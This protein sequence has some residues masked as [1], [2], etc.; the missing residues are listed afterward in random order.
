M[1]EKWYE[2]ESYRKFL[3]SQERDTYLPSSVYGKLIKLIPTDEN[4]YI[5]D[6]RT[7]LGHAALSLADAY[8]KNPRLH[9]FACDF[10]EE[11][12]DHFWYTLAKK[13][14]T[15]VTPFFVPR[16]SAIYFPPWL[17]KMKQI[18]C[19]LTLSSS[20]EPE[21]IIQTIHKIAEANA[22]LHIIEWNKKKLP[23]E[24][25]NIIPPENIIDPEQLEVYLARSN[26]R[27]EK[28]YLADNY[29]FAISAQVPNEGEKV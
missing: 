21:K 23:K 20:E 6:F 25:E 2:H 16:H 8:K 9:I 14:I 17:P 10:Q 18:I 3:S 26:Y 24:L 1:A 19:S 28:S 4:T 11:L 12:L 22:I 5:L 15:N 7:G 13:K 27:I 29:F